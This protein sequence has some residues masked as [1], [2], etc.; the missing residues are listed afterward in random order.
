[1]GSHSHFAHAIIHRLRAGSMIT[2]VGTKSPP[3][4]EKPLA[5]ENGL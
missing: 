2:A 1:M 5:A 3:K 4:D